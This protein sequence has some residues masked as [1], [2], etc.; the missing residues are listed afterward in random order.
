MKLVGV[1][2]DDAREVSTQHLGV[3][4]EVQ[5]PSGAKIEIGERGFLQHLQFETP[6]EILRRNEDFENWSLMVLSE[7]VGHE[8]DRA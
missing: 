5:C 6:N 8:R 7:F 3:L 4:Y 1:I 2:Y